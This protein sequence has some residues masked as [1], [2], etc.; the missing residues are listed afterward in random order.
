MALILCLET[1]TTNCSVALSENGSVIAFREDTSKQYSHAER[2]HVFINEVLEETE[3]GLSD[4][5]AIAVSKG[6]GSYTGLR[7]GVSAAK[8][9]CFSLDVPLLAIPTLAI[10]ASQVAD[11]VDFIVPMID[12]RRM[13]VY[14]MV[15]NKEIQEVREI[16]AEI[17]DS[18][19]FSGFLEK[20]KVAFIGNGVSKFQELCKHP[21]ALFLKERLPSALQMASMAEAQNKIGNVVNV[22]YFEPF[23]LKDFIL[24]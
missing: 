5:D 13:E 4:L 24:G 23:Y 2:L 12:A 18:S 11:D 14:A 17:L 7:I 3:Y 22:A 16:K 8:G 19:S 1:A 10:L 6:P 15:L 9:L 21:N 20:G